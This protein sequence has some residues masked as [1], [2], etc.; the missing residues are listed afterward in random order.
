MELP[1]PPESPPLSRRNTTMSPRQAHESTCAPHM[2]SRL[3]IRNIFKLQ[4]M[5]NTECNQFLDTYPFQYPI[6]F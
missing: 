1:E 5:L 4:A 3:F 2:I 6:F